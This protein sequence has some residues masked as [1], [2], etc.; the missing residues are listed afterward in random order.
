MTGLAT[1]TSATTTAPA[2]RGSQSDGDLAV[3]IAEKV[4]AHAVGLPDVDAD[5]VAAQVQGGIWP[6]A[7]LADLRERAIEITSATVASEPSYSKLA[8][9]LLAEH[10]AEET[11]AE[12]VVSFTTSIAACRDN[13]LLSEELIAFVDAHGPELDAVVD[14]AADDRFEYFGLRTVYDRYLLRHPEHRTVLE[15]P[16]YFMLRV[17]CGLSQTVAEAAELYRL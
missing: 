12:G 16:Q 4:R 10:I 11:E 3:A 14:E 7:T 6:G 1:T 8:A 2:Q 9:R 5:R 15:R 17:A 13:G